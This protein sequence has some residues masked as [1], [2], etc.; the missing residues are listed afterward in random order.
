MEQRKIKETLNKVNK[1]KKVLENKLNEEDEYY[2]NETKDSFNKLLKKMYDETKLKI[3]ISNQDLR[4]LFEA[5]PLKK[6][7]NC[8]KIKLRSE[9]AKCPLTDSR[10]I[11]DYFI[12]ISFING[13][14]NIFLYSSIPSISGIFEHFISSDQTV[15]L[16]FK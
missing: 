13:S 7:G 14:P 15:M 16:Q 1:L 11:F 5:D 2:F 12:E 8:I 4:K 9:M 6:N 3:D 10:I